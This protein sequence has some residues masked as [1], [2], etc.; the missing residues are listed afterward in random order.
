MHDFPRSIP[1]A[2]TGYFRSAVVFAVTTVFIL[3][4]AWAGPAGK[5]T[6]SEHRVARALWVECEGTNRTLDSVSRIDTMIQDAKSW[7]IDTL[8]IQVYRGD[9]AWFSSGV[10][11]DTPCE[12]FE[13]LEKRDM[14]QYLLDAAH[15]QGIR[16]HAW[17][18]VFR[19]GKDPKANIIKNLGR[20]VVTCDNKG[21]SMMEYPQLQLPGKDNLYYEADGTGYWLEPGDPDVQNYLLNVLRKLITKYPA[22]DGVQLD[23][24]RLP[25]VVPFSPGARFPKGITYGYGLRSV[26]RFRAHTRWDPLKWDGA[27]ASA[28]AWDDWRRDQ[29][30]AFVRKARKALKE[31]QPRAQMSA[32]V[33]CWGDRAYLTAFQDWRGW[34][35]EGDVDFVAIMNYSVEAKLSSYVTRTALAFARVRPVWVGLGAYLLGTREKVFSQQIRDTLGQLVENNKGGIGFFSY[36]SL[37]LTPHLVNVMRKGWKEWSRWGT[38][39]R[40]QW[41]SWWS[42]F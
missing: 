36:D 30:T 10:T 33:L 28:Q 35:W 8:F 25:F 18:N 2:K 38:F 24:I 15:R 41:S 13:K 39:V 32:A 17:C 40:I 14:L 26:E 11:D 23:F 37:K 4:P 22:L 12:K 19:V 9:R 31:I 20:R 42:A 29:I 1:G 5:S 7:G 27:T 21:R 3:T 6:A 16:V 34:L